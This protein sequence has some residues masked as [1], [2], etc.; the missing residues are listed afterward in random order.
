MKKNGIV[1]DTMND[2]TKAKVVVY[3]SE[4]CGS[5]DSCAAC[6]QKPITM[7]VANSLQAEIGDQVTLEISDSAFVRSSFM[8]YLVPLA[9]FI[10]GIVVGTVVLDNMGI[11]NEALTLVFGL[12]GLFISFLIGRIVDR[13]LASDDMILM[14]DR[15]PIEE[16]IKEQKKGNEAFCEHCVN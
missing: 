5:C 4:A 8:I 6:D 2:D 12:A 11:Q 15:T 14:I 16:I 1:V 10:I 13:R 7:E 3:R 9:L